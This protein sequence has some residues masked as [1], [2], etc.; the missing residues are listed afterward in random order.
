MI[1]S[2]LFSQQSIKFKNQQALGLAS[3]LVSLSERESKN[4]SAAFRAA[5]AFSS[6]S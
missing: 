5:I 2:D 6:S 4:R 1:K 3:L